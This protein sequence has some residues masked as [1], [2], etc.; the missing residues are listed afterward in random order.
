[1]Y[2]ILI[3]LLLAGCEGASYSRSDASIQL[4]NAF[5]KNDYKFID[6]SVLQGEKWTKV[7]FLGPYNVQSSKMLGF[8][9]NITS[10]TDVLASDGHNVIVFS[11]ESEVIAFIVHDR[12]YGD[13]WQLTGQCFPR[14]KSK[15]YKGTESGAWYIGS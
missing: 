11:T 9:W 5:K 13:F 14:E 4:G 15:L 8:E 2:K 3:L 10:H 6:F 12:G 7:C 1:M